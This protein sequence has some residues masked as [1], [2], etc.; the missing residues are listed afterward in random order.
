MTLQLSC[1]S[2]RIS[3]SPTDGPPPAQILAG[4]WSTAARSPE[5]LER[6][7]LTGADPV[8]PSSFRV[9][10]AAQAS[11]AATALAATEIWRLRTGRAQTVSIDMRA[12]AIEF[13]SERHMRLAGKPPGPTWD[14][15]AGVHRTG[16]GRYV[17][18]HTNFP[19]HRAGMLKLLG[20]AYERE[21]VQA[22]LAKWEGEKF[23]TAAADAK[24]VATMM[25]S[26]AEWAAHGPL[27]G[28]D[29]PGRRRVG[30][31]QQLHRNSG[32]DA[33]MSLRTLAS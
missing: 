26:P 23:E 11:I 16:D 7:A 25:R 5:A 13:R 4:L 32:Q 1:Y 18:L 10:A 28:G 14:K 20:C 30:E 27:R 9:G 22:A 29:G 8:L 12:A 21:A 6:V 15:I 2:A 17:R 19:H 33:E 24:L 3:P 31:D